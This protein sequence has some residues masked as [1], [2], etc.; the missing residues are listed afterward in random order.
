MRSDVPKN[1]RISDIHVKN[2]DKGD[3]KMI[4]AVENTSFFAYWL[5]VN[6]EA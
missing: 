1:L 4:N 6:S 5:M 2:A 3:G